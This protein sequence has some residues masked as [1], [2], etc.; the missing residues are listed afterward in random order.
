LDEGKEEVGGGMG[1]GGG[2]SMGLDEVRDFKRPWRGE[3]G[4]RFARNHARY[5]LSVVTPTT[6]LYLRTKTPPPPQTPH[7]LPLSLGQC[8]R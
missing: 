8:A 5:V 1:G 2:D 4:A 6:A 7:H 3:G